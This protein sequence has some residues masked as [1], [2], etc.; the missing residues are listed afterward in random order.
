MKKRVSVVIPIY[1]EV[2]YLP[3]LI[4]DLKK[5]E[6]RF[7]IILVDDCS[8][9][10]SLEIAHKSGFIVIHHRENKGYGA[11]IKSGIRTATG[12]VI[13]TMDSDGQHSPSDIPNLVEWIE[14]Y[15]MVVGM[16]KGI[17]H[18]R[19]WRIPG[20][21]VLGWL[22]NYLMRRKIPDLNS[23]FRAIKKEIITKYLHICS[24]GFSFSTT[25]T[26]SLLSEGYSVKFIPIQIQKDKGESTVTVKTGME[27]LL[28]IIR[29][30][31]LFNPLRFFL[32]FSLILLFSGVLLVLFMDFRSSIVGLV[33]ILIGVFI[34]FFGLMADQMAHIRRELKG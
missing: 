8:T 34:F 11:A 14:E 15:D 28:L 10:N 23:G 31:V 16:R 20:K 18:T 1:N 22:T 13:I 21:C 4:A 25:S 24:D 3:Q 2:R 5:Y 32:P 27:T 29:I 19:L 17:F 7:E 6:D 33:S 30:I 26:L 9:D 12:D